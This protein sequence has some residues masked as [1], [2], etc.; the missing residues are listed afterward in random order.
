MLHHWLQKRHY[1]SPLPSPHLDSRRRVD[2][3]CEQDSTRIRKTLIVLQTRINLLWVQALGFIFLRLLVPNTKGI[4]AAFLLPFSYYSTCLNYRWPL[5][6]AQVCKKC[7]VLDWYSCRSSDVLLPLSLGSMW[8]GS[9]ASLA[10]SIKQ[11]SNTGKQTALLLC[12]CL[13]DFRID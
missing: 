9:T 13:S 4:C 8:C 6:S 2:C 5:C 11:A 7:A 12:W 3:S 1:W 10:T